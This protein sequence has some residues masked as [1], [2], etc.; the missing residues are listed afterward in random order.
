MSAWALIYQP[1]SQVK[2]KEVKVGSEGERS[3]VG[4]AIKSDTKRKEMVTFFPS[5]R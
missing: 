4:E 5:G 3:G 2:Q 1:E